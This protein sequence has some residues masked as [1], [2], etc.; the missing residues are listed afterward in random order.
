[1]GALP[2]Y[3]MEGLVRYYQDE[4]LPL[5]VGCDLNAH[6][7]VWGST[8]TNRRGEKLLEYLASTDLEILNKESEP[9]FCTAVRR[10]VLDLTICSRQ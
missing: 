1:M 7:T 4:Q 8:G 5:I 9:T 10:E 2:P 3:P 6:H